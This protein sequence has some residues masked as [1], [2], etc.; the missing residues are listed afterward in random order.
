MKRIRYDE[1]DGKLVSKQRFLI[2]DV[3]HYVELDE[4]NQKGIIAHDV[5]AMDARL[6]MVVKSFVAK[7]S[8]KLK[9]AAKNALIELGISFD[10]E[11]RK[12]REGN[13]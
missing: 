12:K 13:D 4:K 1:K 11:K 3:N 10:D 5:I 7:S 8:H 9:I 2:N 6:Q